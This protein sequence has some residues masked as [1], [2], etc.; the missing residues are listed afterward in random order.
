LTIVTQLAKEQPDNE[1]WQSDLSDVHDKL[2]DALREQG[3]LAGALREFRARLAIDAALAEKEPT[4]AD[5]Q[6]DLAGAN[7]RIGLA[8]EAQGDLVGALTASQA[9]LEIQRQL[10]ARD[11]DPKAKAALVDALGENSFYLLFNRRA[12]EAAACAEEA[13][14][15]D[16]S[17]VWI[18]T[19]RAHAY[20]FL[21]RYERAKAIYLE[22]KDKLLNDGRTFAK[23]VNDDFAMF[24]KN[25]IEIPAMHEI[26]VLLSAA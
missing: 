17:A 2:G 3:D 8:L 21:G 20:L 9:A 11:S 24:R 5:R 6:R 25:G 1:T 18:E 13:L 4:N 23:A 15:L 19:N 22:N 14:S 26:E 12:E 10:Y 16:P 7:E